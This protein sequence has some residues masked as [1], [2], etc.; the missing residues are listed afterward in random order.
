M[1]NKIFSAALMV[2]LTMP[3]S[4]VAQDITLPEPNFEGSESLTVVK[5]L[6]TRHSTRE[7]AQTPL[8]YQELS[9]LCWA[10]CGMSRD[11]NH[12]TAPTALN[13]Q[14]IR[15]FVFDKNGVYEYDAKS[16]ALVKKADG[17]QRELIASGGASPANGKAGFRQDFVMDAPV[18]LVMVI[19]FEKMGMDDIKAHQMGAVDAGIVCENINLYCQAVGLA[20]VPRATMDTEGI[21]K[22]LGLTDKQ[23]PIMNNPVGRTK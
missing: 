1:K 13:K 17:D 10:A 11:D 5:A 20:T 14:E 16:N 9:N 19:D 12:R 3:C 8:S 21:R 6:A 7:F 2:G 15:L 22:L 18:S 4:C 23:L